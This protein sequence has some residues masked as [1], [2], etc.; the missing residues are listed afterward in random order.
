MRGVCV[1]VLQERVR[2]GRCC[3]KEGVLAGVA[4]ERVCGVCWQVLQERGYVV[5]VGRRCRREGVW[6][7]LVG[8]AG[9]RVCW[10]VLQERGLS[11]IHI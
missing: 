3:R 9:E 4:G 2:V 5:C 7:V 1:C 8:V 11:L 6:C 10:Q